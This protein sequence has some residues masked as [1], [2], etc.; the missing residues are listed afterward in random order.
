MVDAG[1]EAVL[2][3]VAGIGLTTKHLGKT[4]AQMQPI[5][6]KLV[7]WND[8][9]IRPVP[10]I[11]H[12]YSMSSGARTSAVKAVNMKP[13]P[14]IARSSKN[15]SPCECP[16]YRASLLH[17]FSE[18]YRDEV[19]TVI[20]SDNDFATVAFLRVKHA[21]LEGK[22]SMPPT[23][24]IPPLLDASYQTIEEALEQNLKTMTSSDSRRTDTSTSVHVDNDVI[25][26][27]VSSLDSWVAVSQVQRDASGDDEVKTPIEAEV[28]ECFDILRGKMCFH[29]P[30]VLCLVLVLTGRA[31]QLLKYSLSLQHISS[32]SVFLSDMA[33]FPLVNAVFATY[34]GISPPARACVAV[35]LPLPSRIRLE[36][37]A[38]HDPKPG[39]G[40]PSRQALHVQGLSYWAPAN[41]GPYSQAILVQR[42]PSRQTSNSLMDGPVILDRRAHLHLGANWI[43][44]QQS[45]SPISKISRR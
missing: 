6:V 40:L 34:F 3:K 13:S 41:I 36:C 37:L 10:L 22:S 9:R 25:N 29:S 24:R 17:Q 28:R 16:C 11:N 45:R 31:A 2:I 20:H 12:P 8:A 35:D 5:L 18:Y 1:M 30:T 7:S 42:L 27:A 38:R 19:E 23:I 14:W 4:L 32:I 43:D 44:T 33:L 39:D 26:G 21:R 15:E